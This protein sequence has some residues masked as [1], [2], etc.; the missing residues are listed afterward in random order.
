MLS[1]TLG[2]AG[3]C[4]VLCLL[5]PQLLTVADIR[6]FYHVP[7]VRLALQLVLISA[8]I[9]GIV[10]IS[11]RQNR[12]L[13]GVGIAI[14]LVASLMGGSRASQRFDGHS[15]V[16]FGLDFFLL[17]LI[18]LGTIFI[19]IERLFR[20]HDQ[21]I[22][23]NEWREDVFYF[24]VSALFVQSLAYL[25]LTP[26]MVLLQQTEWAS[27]FRSMVASQPLILQ[28]LEIMLFTDFVQ[29]WFHRAFHEVPWLWK[30]H[31]VHHSARQMD[32]LAGSRMHV[33][34]IVLLRAF[35]TLPMYVLGF[36]ESALYAYI[37]FVYLLSTFIHSNVRFEFGFLQH[38]IAT[39]RFHHWHHGVE[40]EAINVNYAIHFPMLDKLFRT[41]HLPSNEW[42]EGYGIAQHPVPQGYWR[43]FLYPFQAKS[44]STSQEESDKQTESK[45]AE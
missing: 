1:I 33:V 28:F 10:S 11:L 18:L 12:L 15:D 2:I 9:L 25:S 38:I 29:Y 6:G 42:P 44:T 41:H 35:T 20:K 43:Q 21:P 40:K 5:Y 19:P 22:F 16:Y 8:F 27:G 32:W 37:F 30:F 4:T 39:P 14:V 3:L 17:N 26:S 45:Q 23:R 24:F 34:E 31:A 7:M 36:A 13:G